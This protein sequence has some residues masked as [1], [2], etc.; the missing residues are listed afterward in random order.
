MIT[1]SRTATFRG[2]LAIAALLILLPFHLMGAYLLWRS[3]GSERELVE[4]QLR[5]VTS[6]AA[7]AADADVEEWRKGLESLAQFAGD[8]GNTE[9]AARMMGEYLNQHRDTQALGLLRSDGSFAVRSGQLPSSTVAAAA[10]A[11]KLPESSEGGWHLSGVLLLE[12]AKGPLIGAAIPLR[13]GALAGGTLLAL[14]DASMI[15]LFL[16]RD[17]DHVGWQAAVIDQNNVIAAHT[18]SELAGQI[19]PLA[20]EMNSRQAKRTFV[21]D[22]VLNGVSTYIAMHR[23][24]FAPWYVAYMVPSDVLDAPRRHSLIDAVMFVAL[25]A[26]PITASALLGRYLGRRIQKLAEAA[27]SISSEQA[28]PY[29]PP[30]GLSEI[31]VVQQALQHAGEVAQERAAARERVQVMEEA[32]HRAERMESLGQLMASISHDFGNLIFTIRGNLEVIQRKLHDDERMQQMITRPLRLADEAAALIAQLSAGVRHKKNCPERININNVLS[33]V[34][35]L[36]REV[37]GRGIRLL[38]TPGPGLF[39]CKLDPV[40][41]KSALLNLVINARNAMPR[42]GK[43]EIRSLNPVMS[44]EAA[45]AS[46]LAHAGDYVSLSVTDTG[47]GI[48]PEIRARIFEPFF[49]TREGDAGTGIGLSILHEFVKAAG[50]S[51]QV[52]STMGGGTTFTMYFPVEPP[53]YS[54]SDIAAEQTTPPMRA[55]SVIVDGSSR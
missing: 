13:Q 47:T 12:G 27:A 32:L 45:H 22:G 36:L 8:G 51:V 25:L 30:T 17:D 24:N 29:L 40:L 42:G 6:M 46:D 11:M 19:F 16:P 10:A 18:N 35:G 52:D 44:E 34:A 48:P 21:F 53:T 33:E 3:A 1:I 55:R 15:D 7:A 14:N 4:A 9:A 20:K 49:T 31:D 43:I 41:L 39:D 50:G 2:F 37:A 5:A 26:M 23:C 28:P 38:I 54:K